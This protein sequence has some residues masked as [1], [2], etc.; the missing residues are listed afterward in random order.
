MKHE[1]FLKDVDF[2]NWLNMNSLET[3]TVAEYK[4]IYILLLYNKNT[5]YGFAIEDN[6]RL[7]GHGFDVISEIVGLPQTEYEVLATNNTL[8]IVSNTQDYT[9]IGINVAKQIDSAFRK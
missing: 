4:G 8:S 6:D 2:Y 9:C 5:P 3:W 1:G 7:Q